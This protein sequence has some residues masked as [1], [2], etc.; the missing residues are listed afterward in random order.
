MLNKPSGNNDDGLAK[1]NHVT[2]SWQNERVKSVRTGSDGCGKIKDLGFK[3]S[4]HIKMYSQR[5]EIV[6]DPF[7]E[8]DCLAVCAT[9]E[10]DPEVRTLLL[11]IAI[12]VGLAERFLKRP[13][14]IG[15][16]PRRLGVLPDARFATGAVTTPFIATTII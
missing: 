12:L 15:E 7:D 8:G 5:F 9:S 2:N 13:G 4:M 11:P 6:S 10:N 14:L 3:T 16:S 1:N